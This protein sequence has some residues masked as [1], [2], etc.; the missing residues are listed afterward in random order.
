MK[1]KEIK[2]RKDLPPMVIYN[3]NNEETDF[4]LKHEEVDGRTVELKRLSDLY[5]NED[6]IEIDGVRVPSIFLAKTG[7][8]KISEEILK[9]H[10]KIPQEFKKFGKGVIGRTNAFNGQIVSLSDFEIDKITEEVKL[11]IRQARYFDFLSTNISIDISLKTHDPFFQAGMVLRDYEIDNGK[12]VSLSRSN[13]AN[14][15]GVDFFITSEENEGNYFMFVRGSEN[16]AIHFDRGIMSCPGATPTWS[17]DLRLTGFSNYLRNLI[18]V[19]LKEELLLDADEFNIGNCYFYK[20]LIR[21]PEVIIQIKLIKSIEDIALKCQRNKSVL[22]ECDRIYAVPAEIEALNSLTK[23]G[24][25]INI[26]TK[27]G[28]YLILEK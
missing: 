27:T 14:M 12:E 5:F 15:L 9:E 7:L 3:L 16:H 28:V 10:Y 4:K 17:E 19:E 25:D 24:Y 18:E 22:E 8:E 26:T 6:L 11:K 2:L 13:L 21:G 1:S 23:L 20:N